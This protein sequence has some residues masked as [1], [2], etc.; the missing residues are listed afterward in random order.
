MKLI[1]TASTAQKCINFKS[2]MAKNERYTKAGYLKMP[3]T[4]F[5]LDIFCS[6]FHLCF[7]VLMLRCFPLGWYHLVLMTHRIFYLPYSAKLTSE[8]RFHPPL[9]K[10]NNGWEI[11]RLDQNKLHCWLGEQLYSF[12]C[13]LHLHEV[14]KNSL[15]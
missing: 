8:I 2:L 5:N 14:A 10:Q 13:S 6:S 7:F 3:G 15:P 9:Q 12:S 1:L 4:V 11:G